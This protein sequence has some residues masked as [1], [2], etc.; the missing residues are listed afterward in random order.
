MESYIG[1]VVQQKGVSIRNFL[2]YAIKSA[3]MLCEEAPGALRA[4]H[5]DGVMVDISEPGGATAAEAAGLPFVTVCNAVPLHS[6]P[7]T[8]P[9]FLPWRYRDAWWARLRNQLAYAVRNVIIS[10]LHRVLN[11][12]RREWNLRPYW[13]PDDSFSQLAQITQLVPEFDLPRSRLPTC[14]HYVGPYRREA[15]KSIP[16]PYDRLDGRP[17]IYASLGTVFGGRT[18]L[19]KAILE[20]C[21]GQNMQV[22]ISLGGHRVELPDARSNTIVVDYG[23]QRELLRRASLAITHAGLNTVMEACAAG[24]PL[25]AMPIT[26]DQFGAAARVSYANIGEVVPV[27]KCHGSSIQAAVQKIL[28]SSS[29]AVHAAAIR[30]AIDRTNGARSAAE[31]IEDVISARRPDMGACPGNSGNSHGKDRLCSFGSG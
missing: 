5:A 4:I 11:R 18:E 24:V 29:Y 20:G 30:R 31:I 8:P 12:Y 15:E 16:F 1:L 28:G 9:D 17:L 27:S 22:I 23:P 6:D 10:P 2:D 3:T 26:G 7:E 25:V 14:F 19:W 21:S 13:S